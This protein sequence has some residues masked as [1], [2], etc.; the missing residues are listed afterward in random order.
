MKLCYSDRGDRVKVQLNS[1][2]QQL[3]KFMIGS[4]SS[5]HVDHFRITWA[6]TDGTPTARTRNG[7]SPGMLTP[8]YHALQTLQSR[9]GFG[10][11]Q[12]STYRLGM[13]RSPRRFS[14]PPA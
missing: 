4:R 1:V 10:G 8:Y 13:R 5:G 12:P 3:A 6:P 9:Y 7:F 14:V 2:T 11:V